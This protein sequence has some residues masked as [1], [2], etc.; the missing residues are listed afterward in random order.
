MFWIEL[1]SECFSGQQRSN[2]KCGILNEMIEAS[3]QKTTLIYLEQ[4]CLQIRIKSN[5]WCD[6][7][8][9]AKI[10]RPMSERVRLWC[11]DK[12]LSTN[13]CHWHNGANVFCYYFVCDLTLVIVLSWARACKLSIFV[14]IGSLQGP[15]SLLIYWRKFSNSEIIKKKSWFH[16]CCTQLFFP[17]LLLSSTQAGR[18]FTNSFLWLSQHMTTSLVNCTCNSSLQLVIS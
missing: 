13:K 16:H 6:C 3:S 11:C 10:W 9:V 1:N 14:K 4:G 8:S 17:P 15:T 7:L 12:I 18:I 5:Q 2:F